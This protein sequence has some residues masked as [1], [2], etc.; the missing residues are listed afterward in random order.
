M[1]ARRFRR[2][3]GLALSTFSG[4]ALSQYAMVG[5]LGHFAAESFHLVRATCAHRPCGLN[6]FLFHL[7]PPVLR[8]AIPSHSECPD[9][10][11]DMLTL[12]VTLY[13]MDVHPPV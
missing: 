7:F 5:F 6:N 12:P 8:N 9:S 1:G 4:V 10:R 2:E 13:N 11:R 3:Q